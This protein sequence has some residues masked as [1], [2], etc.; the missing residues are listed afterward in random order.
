[1]TINV[2]GTMYDLY[3]CQADKMQDKDN[4]GECDR[5]AKTILINTA[6]FQADDVVDNV[7]EVKQKVIRHEIIHA[8][9]HEAGL[10]CY[11]EDEV[12]V[13]ALSILYPK[14]R[15]TIENVAEITKN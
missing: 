15:D 12:L 5:Y 8:F 9:F 3:E 4:Y 14:I 10:D 6:L 2:L 7:M 1:M 11:S 13:D